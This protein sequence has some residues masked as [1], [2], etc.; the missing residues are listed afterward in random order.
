M[1]CTNRYCN[2]NTLVKYMD[3]NKNICEI[4][5][6]IYVNKC[7]ICGLNCNDSCLDLFAN[8]LKIE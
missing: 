7:D 4:C 1:N 6:S 2:K 3:T 8:A 5:L